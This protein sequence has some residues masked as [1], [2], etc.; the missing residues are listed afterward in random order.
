MLL[1]VG[2]SGE[3]AAAHQ[4]AIHAGATTKRS[5][6]PVSSDALRAALASAVASAPSSLFGPTR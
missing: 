5:P 2:A 4:A 3:H 1:V 6:T